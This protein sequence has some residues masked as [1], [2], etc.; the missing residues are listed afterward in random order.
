MNIQEPHH[1]V[2]IAYHLYLCRAYELSFQV[3]KNWV[4]ILI[5]DIYTESYFFLAK[6]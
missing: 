6:K 2:C 5:T 1:K 4:N 3:Y